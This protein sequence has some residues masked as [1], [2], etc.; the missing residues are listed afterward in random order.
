MYFQRIN[1]SSPEQ[2]FLMVQNA[3]DNTMMPGNAPMSIQKNA[4]KG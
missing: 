2:V 4:A 1:S 3:T